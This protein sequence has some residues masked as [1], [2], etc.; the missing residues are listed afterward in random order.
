MRRLLSPYGRPFPTQRAPA[1]RPAVELDLVE[2][3]AL[4]AIRTA[5]ERGLEIGRDLSVSTAIRL[6]LLAGVSIDRSR[7][8]RARLRDR[9][10]A[11]T[12]LPWSTP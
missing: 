8:Q 2:Q 1:P 6:G 5:G 11:R 12:H 3:S 10:P 4:R 7:P 9:A